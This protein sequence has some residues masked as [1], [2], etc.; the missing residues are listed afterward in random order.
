[1]TLEV[2]MGVG[3]IQSGMFFCLAAAAV[4]VAVAVAVDMVCLFAWAG[5][6]VESAGLCFM[7]SEAAA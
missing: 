4:A 6:G 7:R 5:L 1:M 2:F 3:A